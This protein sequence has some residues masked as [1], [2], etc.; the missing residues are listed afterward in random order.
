MTARPRQPARSTARAG[1]ISAAECARRFGITA[2]ALGLW[3]KR[4]GAPVRIEGRS[5][6]CQWPGIA[7]WREQELCRQAVAEATR[8]YRTAQ[9]TGQPRDPLDRKLEADAR[10]AEIEVER[11]EHQTVNV[12]D[13][14]ALFDAVMTNVRAV[15][16]PFARV[17]APK[18]V[19]CDTI[20]SVEQ[21]LHREVVRVMQQMAVPALVPTPAAMT[22]QAA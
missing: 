16:M 21:A 17:V 20:V 4:V 5:V 14:V 18:V 10:K 9:A 7:R 22:E 1:E 13:A 12:A 6:W 3:T 11:L 8:S 19:A 15:L 2:S